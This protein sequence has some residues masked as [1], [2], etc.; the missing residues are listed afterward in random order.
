MG[1]GFWKSKKT[2]RDEALPSTNGELIYAVGDIHGRADLLDNLLS[3]I[4][5]DMSR[6]QISKEPFLVFLG[7]YIDRGPASREVVERLLS[8][9]SEFRMVAIKGNHEDALLRF[10]ESPEVGPSWIQH[11][12]AETLASY[13]VVSLPAGESGSWTETRNEFASRLP[14]THH[15]FFSNLSPYLCLGDYV[16]VHAGVRPKVRLEAQ[17]ERDMMWIRREFLETERAIDR[18][19]VHGHTPAEQAHLGRWRIGVDTGAYATGVLT[20]VLLQDAHQ[21]ILD[22]RGWNP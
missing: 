13:G 22:T 17:T 15:D 21:E 7:D 14:R 20:A 10:L 16:F 11:G 5:A 2:R 9:Q 12:G 18:I 4:R 8:L 19:V 6:R 1:F 3:Q